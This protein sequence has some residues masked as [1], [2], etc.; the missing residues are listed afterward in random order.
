MNWNYA[1]VRIKLATY[2]TIIIVPTRPTG[3][4]IAAPEHGP[5]FSLETENEG[6]YLEKQSYDPVTIS[7]TEYYTLA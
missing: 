1:L 5:L 4:P 6:K 3:R 2:R 7:D